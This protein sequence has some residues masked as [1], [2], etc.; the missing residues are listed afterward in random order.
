[1]PFDYETARIYTKYGEW[2]E[3]PDEVYDEMAKLIEDYQ[4]QNC[5]ID[6][7][8]PPYITEGGTIEASLNLRRPRK[9]TVMKTEGLIKIGTFN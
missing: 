9:W 3:I 1:M 6:R 2:T 5:L 4:C 8:I 7:M